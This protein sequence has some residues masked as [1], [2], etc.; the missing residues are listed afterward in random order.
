MGFGRQ[1]TDTGAK[2]QQKEAVSF[3]E[4]HIDWPG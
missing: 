1:G 2:R 3:T 4:T